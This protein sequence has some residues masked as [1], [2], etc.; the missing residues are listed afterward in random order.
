[1]LIPTASKSPPLLWQVLEQ[2]WVPALVCWP[3]TN[4][5]IFANETDVEGWDF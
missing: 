5:F 1:M 4:L 2:Y 3:N